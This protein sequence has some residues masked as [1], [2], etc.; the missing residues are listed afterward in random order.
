MPVEKIPGWFEHLLLLKLSKI[1]GEVKA[2]DTKIEGID[3]RFSGIDHRFEA[4]HARLDS[5]GKRIPVIEEITLHRAR[6]KEIE[7]RTA[8]A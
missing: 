6:I 1:S 8:A 4:V 5:I 3:Y 7:K 2:L